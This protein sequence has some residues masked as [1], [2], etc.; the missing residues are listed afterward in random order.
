MGAG[1]VVEKIAHGLEAKAHGGPGGIALEIETTPQ[2]AGPRQ[3]AK[4]DRERIGAAE[5]TPAGE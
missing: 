3:R 1:K 2:Q 5:L 4:R